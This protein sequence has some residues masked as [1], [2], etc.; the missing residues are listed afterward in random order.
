M[1][2]F[3]MADNSTDYMTRAEVK[4][5]VQAWSSE[6]VFGVV[7]GLG[8]GIGLV[9]FLGLVSSDGLEAAFTLDGLLDWAL[10]FA[11]GVLFVLALLSARKKRKA[12][13]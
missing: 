1:R 11:A 8:I 7:A 13:E 2:E 6:M 3:A 9:N 12:L 4:D 10:F 5:Y